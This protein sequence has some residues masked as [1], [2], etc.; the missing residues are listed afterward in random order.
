MTAEKWIPIMEVPV[1]SM[2]NFLEKKKREG[3]SILGLEQTANSIP[4]D[5]YTF[6]QKVVM[7]FSG[8]KQ[9]VKFYLCSNVF[10]VKFFI[11]AGVGSWT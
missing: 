9:V 2:K 1:K 6:P 4:L 5:K 8:I 10:F 7:E 11:F 3:Y